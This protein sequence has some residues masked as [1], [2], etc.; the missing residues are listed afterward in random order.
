MTGVSKLY[1]FLFLVEHSINSET[2]QWKCE[3]TDSDNFA[4]HF[5]NHKSRICR[6]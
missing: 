2:V 4:N 1:I 5:L 6:E 3:W